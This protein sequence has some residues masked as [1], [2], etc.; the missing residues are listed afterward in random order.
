MGW[1]ITESAEEFLDEAGELLR[2]DRARNTVLLTVCEVMRVRPMAGALL[3]WTGG[4]A[5]A[6][7]PPYPVVL[8]DMPNDEAVCLAQALAAR[9]RPL[10]GVNAHPDPAAAF[11]AEWER[12]ANV[13][14]VP[15]RSLRL[16]RLGDLVA[17]S[18]M[19]AGT[20]R[21]ADSADAGLVLD[22]YQAFGAETN[23]MGRV[24]RDAVGGIIARG[25]V[26]LWEDGGQPV[27]TASV[28]RSA[29]GMVRIN[30]VYTPPRQRGHGYAAAVTHDLSRAARQQGVE[31]ILLYTDLANPITNR[32]YPRLGYRRVED[33]V[34]LK[35]L[36]IGNVAPRRRLSAYLITF[37]TTPRV[38]RQE[39]SRYG[40]VH[41]P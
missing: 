32:L 30:A 2:R 17:P 13:T 4:A 25:G 28:S 5:F 14:A 22:W 8:T 21:V 33:R 39:A 37:R 23:D 20:C 18:P 24:T 27:S 38:S 3:G 41:D 31:E 15:H 7:T 26:R 34:V 16:Y 19:P 9:D 6:H 11:A 1:N 35:F 40:L 36:P 29:A 12:L 10:S